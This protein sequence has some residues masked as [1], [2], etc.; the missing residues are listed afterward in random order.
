MPGSTGLWQAHLIICGSTCHEFKCSSARVPA[1]VVK[2]LQ[3]WSGLGCCHVAQH[4]MTRLPL[5][6]SAVRKKQQ[7]QH[8]FHAMIWYVRINTCALFCSTCPAA[9]PTRAPSTHPRACSAAAASA[10]LAPIGCAASAVA[11]V[12]DCEILFGLFCL[13]LVCSQL[14]YPPNVSPQSV[15]APG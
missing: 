2:Q 10:V 11:V 13:S 5:Q 12:A 8:S 3:K 1:C 7:N 15:A 14:L 4:Q 6:P 9:S